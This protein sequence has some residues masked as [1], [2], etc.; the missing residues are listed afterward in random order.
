MQK[1]IWGLGA[2]AGVLC[3]VLEYLFFKNTGASANTMYM[4]KMAILIISVI[5]GLVLVKKLIGGSISIAR[6]LLSGVLI[7]MVRALVMIAAFSFLYYPSGDFYKT[8]LDTSY[9]QAAKKI[10]ADSKIKPADKGMKLE[11]LKVQIKKQYEPMGYA[12][13]TLGMSIVTGLI[14]SVLMAA[15]IGTNMMYETEK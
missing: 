13:I 2:L 1:A 3:A 12:L 4:A 8:K 10:N 9:E 14:I 15:F 5:F 11:E 7:A 6:T